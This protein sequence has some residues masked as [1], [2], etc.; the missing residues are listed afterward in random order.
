M[1]ANLHHLVFD[2][3]SVRYVIRQGAFSENSLWYL[4][5]VK[6]EKEFYFISD[7]EGKKCSGILSQILKPSP[8]DSDVEN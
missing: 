2:F 6:V 5:T 7:I 4:S 3:T 1:E 8:K